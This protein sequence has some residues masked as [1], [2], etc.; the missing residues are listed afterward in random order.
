[1]SPFSTALLGMQGVLALAMVGAGGA[2][3]GG[4]ESQI[5]E[6][7]RYGYPQWFRL[8]TGSIELLA[9][10]VLVAG[11]FVTPVL[12]LGGGLLV[13]VTMA[14]AVVTHIRVGDSAA[15]IAPSAILLAVAL[16]VSLYHVGVF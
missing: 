9:G 11:F 12:A 2:K 10:V 7:Q 13:V 15:D 6:F 4:I 1:M 8:V 16:L 3:L 5:E 14:G